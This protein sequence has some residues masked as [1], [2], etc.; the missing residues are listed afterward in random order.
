M[1]MPTSTASTCAPVGLPQTAGVLRR[2]SQPA[3]TLSQPQSHPPRPLPCRPVGVFHQ[4][5]H[6]LPRHGEA[7]GCVG[8]PCARM[9]VCVLTGA[10][11]QGRW[12]TNV[13]LLLLLLSRRPPPHQVHSL[14]PNPRSH[15]QEGWRI[16][17]FFSHHPEALHMVRGGVWVG[18]VTSAPR[19]LASL[20]LLPPTPP[21]HHLNSSRSC[22]TTWA[23][24]STTATWRALAFTPSCCSTAR[25]GRRWSSST[26]SQH[27]VSGVVGGAGGGS[28]TCPTCSQLLLSLS[29]GS[30]ST[31]HLTPPH[32]TQ[33]PSQPPHPLRCQVPA[34]G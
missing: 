4:G 6:L 1:L 5:R 12:C 19:L 7:R 31:T 13:L 34:G 9:F 20:S 32:P 18:V 24:P 30:H 29:P 22:W 11:P 16:A 2:A 10:L 17:D 26:G 27:A 8:V 14:K 21:P 25:A 28:V 15:I 3:A 33:P 23:C